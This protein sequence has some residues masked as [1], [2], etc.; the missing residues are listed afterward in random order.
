MGES[1]NPLKPR[2]REG[3]DIHKYLVDLTLDAAREEADELFKAND[4]RAAVTERLAEYITALAN[5]QAE[6]ENLRA[7]TRVDQMTELHNHRAFH[8]DLEALV[9]QELDKS[10]RGESEDNVGIVTV[11]RFDVGMLNMQNALRGHRA[12]DQY[13][14]T[15]A[16]LIRT[17]SQNLKKWANTPREKYLYEKF[18]YFRTYVV[19]GDEFAMIVKGTKSDVET[20]LGFLHDDLLSPESLLDEF[21][22]LEINGETYHLDRELFLD[23]GIAYLDKEVQSFLS[24]QSGESSAKAAI[25]LD[26]VSDQCVDSQK[27]IKRLRFFASLVSEKR[28]RLFERVYPYAA[29]GA[30]EVNREELEEMLRGDLGENCRNFVIRIMLARNQT[31][32]A[33]VDDPFRKGVRQFITDHISSWVSAIKDHG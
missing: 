24:I 10:S 5:A 6:N 12:G 29:K 4:Q 27:A 33:R 18:D 25:L 13:K 32:M 26:M 8:E 15:M 14:I 3:Y 28:F 20:F 31:E 7:S 16:D 22:A 21:T 30:L 2:P 23:Y 1:D 9:S 11:V 19:G 17:V